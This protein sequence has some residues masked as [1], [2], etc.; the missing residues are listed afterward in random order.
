M[1]KIKSNALN[2]FLFCLHCN[3][4][5]VCQK[6]LQI[7]YCNRIG[8]N[9]AELFI[10]TPLAGIFACFYTMDLLFTSVTPSRDCPRHYGGIRPD[11][12][13]ICFHIVSTKMNW[14]DARKE[15]KRK[16]GDLVWFNN[17]REQSIFNLFVQLYNGAVA[18]LNQKVTKVWLGIY[19]KNCEEILWSGPNPT[20]RHRA[21]GFVDSNHKND[22]FFI[23]DGM[24]Y[25]YMPA[26]SGYTK[27]KAI[28]R[29]NQPPRR[30]R[31]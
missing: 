14:W 28:C 15:C 31:R 22:I 10:M 21:Y 4:C 27:Y 18:R 6:R 1:K 17:I 29:H 2:L 13:D 26:R 20:N 19:R 3:R 5:S 11:N 30:R 16:N 8:A 25:M 7:E 12:N 24:N 23:S 9:T